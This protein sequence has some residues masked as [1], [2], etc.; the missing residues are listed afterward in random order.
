MEPNWM[1]YECKLQVSDVRWDRCVKSMG[2]KEMEFEPLVPGGLFL[3][4]EKFAMH[5]V[6]RAG[7]N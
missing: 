1:M 4:Q 5:W 2:W 7:V 3:M 6:A